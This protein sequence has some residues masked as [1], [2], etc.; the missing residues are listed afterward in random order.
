MKIFRAMVEELRPFMQSLND[1]L[2][3][4]ACRK[5][6]GLVNRQEDFLTPQ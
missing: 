1:S 4:A 2:E 6:D 3:D 5:F